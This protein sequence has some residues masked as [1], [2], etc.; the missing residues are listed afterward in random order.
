[1]KADEQT[2]T[3]QTPPLDEHQQGRSPASA[4]LVTLAGLRVG[5]MFKL[6]VPFEAASFAFTE[7]GR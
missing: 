5:E 6:A 7:K 2:L 1:M 3:E 4:F